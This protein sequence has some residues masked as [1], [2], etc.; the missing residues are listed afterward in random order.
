MIKRS[1]MSTQEPH[2]SESTTEPRPAP[3]SLPELLDRA[4][5]WLKHSG[6]QAKS[7]T[8]RGGLHAWIDESTGERAFLYPEITG[9]FLTLCVNLSRHLPE[10]DW[11]ERAERAAEW[12]LRHGMTSTGAV[13]GR[14]YVDPQVGRR[15]PRSN[16]HPHSYFFNCGVVGL[17]LVALS[18]ATGNDRW[19][20]AA[21]RIGSFCLQAFEPAD[22]LTHHAGFDLST[23]S[24]LIGDRWSQHGG[25]F[26]LKAALFLERL[27]KLGGPA[28][29]GAFFERL[30]ERTL[31]AQQVNGRFPTDPTGDTTHLHSHLYTLEALLTLGAARGDSALLDRAQSGLEWAL[32][33]CLD[34]RRCLQQWSRREVAIIRGVRTDML[35]QTL[36]AVE[37]LQWMR[38]DWKGAP[39]RQLTELEQLLGEHRLPSGGLAYGR[40]E[41]GE[42]PF[43]ANAW[44]LFFD[45]E[46]ELFG[47]LRRQE[48]PLEPHR[49]LIT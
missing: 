9:Y 39:T 7:G 23:G 12:I 21:R 28:E 36:R 29:L 4:T 47:A 20:A 32:E 2:L 25:P 35:A 3:L 44:C 17:G 45:I 38:P 22:R 19:R 13:L 49:F 10:D 16:Q 40:D 48:T 27:T 8:D 11:L 24:P 18:E 43:H 14:K 42:K 34:P 30:L 1:T 41:L 31:A 15:D 37:I 6:I 33:T 5:R 26:L 46:R